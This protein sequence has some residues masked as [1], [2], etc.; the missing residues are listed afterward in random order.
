MTLG[1]SLLGIGIRKMWK[2]YN[3]VLLFSGGKGKVLFLNHFSF[4]LILFKT[5]LNWKNE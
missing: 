5:V 1:I 3:T 2:K 4:H